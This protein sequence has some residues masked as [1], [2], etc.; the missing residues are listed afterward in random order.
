MKSE[1]VEPQSIE[2]DGNVITESSVRIMYGE[3]SVPLALFREVMTMGAD[4][5][6]L[7]PAL[8][9]ELGRSESLLTNWNA[10]ARTYALDTLQHERDRILADELGKQVK[11]IRAEIETLHRDCITPLDPD[12]TA[13]DPRTPISKHR[14]RSEGA[15]VSIESPEET[16]RRVAADHTTPK[17]PSEIA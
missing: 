2:I 13:G 14:Q 16:A 4:L 10:A 7:R 17:P 3:D 9:Y 1:E 6:E 15:V 11:R 5:D 8:R 12:P